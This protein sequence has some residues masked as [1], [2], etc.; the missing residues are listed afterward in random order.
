MNKQNQIAD[1]LVEKCRSLFPNKKQLFN[2]Y[3][4]RIN[5]ETYLADGFGVGFGAI[6]EIESVTGCLR[7]AQDF[8]IPLS[9]KFYSLE[10]NAEDRQEFEKELMAEA[11][12]LIKAIAQDVN[13]GGLASR[14][15]FSGSPGIQQVFGESQQYIFLTLTFNASFKENL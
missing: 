2:P 7:F 13:L 9:R 15:V 4:V 1:Y 10:N 14:T 6:Q 12:V 3:D 11:M 5:N 8:L